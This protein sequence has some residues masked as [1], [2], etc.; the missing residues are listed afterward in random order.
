MS[1]QSPLSSFA[2]H[3]TCGGYAWQ[4]NGR[5]K[6]QPHTP[7]CPQY[8]E[9]ALWVEEQMQQVHSLQKEN[10]ELRALAALRNYRNK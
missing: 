6:A 3:C 10:A 2:N 7:W 8:E 4:L 9:Y 1:Q 5:P